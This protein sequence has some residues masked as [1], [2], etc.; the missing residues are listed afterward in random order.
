MEVWT[1]PES[2]CAWIKSGA[3]AT[4][5][6]GMTIHPHHL[7]RHNILMDSQ[8][9]HVPSFQWLPKKWLGCWGALRTAQRPLAILL[10]DAL[11]KPKKISWLQLHIQHWSFKFKSNIMAVEMN[12]LFIYFRDKFGPSSEKGHLIAEKEGSRERQWKWLEKG[13]L[14]REMKNKSYSTLITSCNP[15][16]TSEIAWSL[17]TEQ[18][19]QRVEAYGFMWV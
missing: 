14:Y 1:Q 2:F 7:A 4:F 10:L 17:V 16:V 5:T 6:H 13:Q 11:C 9:S 3:A 15:I 19:S 18:G 8:Q 12:L